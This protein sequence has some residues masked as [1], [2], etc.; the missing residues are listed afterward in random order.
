MKLDIMQCGSFSCHPYPSLQNETLS[1][2]HGYMR[3]FTRKKKRT[4]TTEQLNMWFFQKNNHQQKLKFCILEYGTRK[5]TKFS[6]AF[7]KATFKTS[8]KKLDSYARVNLHTPK[9]LIIHFLTS[10]ESGGKCLSHNFYTLVE[11]RYKLK[12]AAV[13]LVRKKQKRYTN[14]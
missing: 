3:R 10:I 13:W 14:T 7:F 8:Q 5:R 6:S 9:M 12:S 11:K 2:K 4:V 1:D